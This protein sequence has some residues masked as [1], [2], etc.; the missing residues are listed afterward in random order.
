MADHVDTVSVAQTDPDREQ[1][2]ADLGLVDDEYARIRD[3][4]CRRPTSSER[5]LSS[6]MLSEHGSYQTRT[7]HLK[8]L[9][10]MV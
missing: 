8:Q 6:A 7:V 9:C 10:R 2:F 5:A 3:I 1:P 4:L